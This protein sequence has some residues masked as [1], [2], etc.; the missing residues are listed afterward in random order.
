MPIDY[1]KFDAIDDSDEENQPASSSS[2]ADILRTLEGMQRSNPDAK[3]SGPLRSPRGF[4]DSWDDDLH[5]WDMGMRSPPSPEDDD[6]Y[7]LDFEA[8]NADALQ[9]LGAR[10]ASS[11]N[12]SGIGRSL[13][14]EAE[15]Q[16][17]ASRYREALI[18]SLAAQLVEDPS[19]LGGD[20]ADSVP[21][22]AIQMISAYQLGDRAEAT[23]LRDL[24][25][26]MP[27]HKLSEHLRKR[28][29]GTSE[30]LDLV[31]KF[32]DIMKNAEKEPD[33]GSF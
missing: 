13:L 31:P 6:S 25:K 8:L 24:L 30:V 3:Q 29:E 14:L 12:V 11:T 15:L 28:F 33:R 19:Q 10:L 22:L 5:D 32:L 26:E 18:A 9:L 16:L 4:G 7:S 2:V 21:A 17:V 23:Q 20:G 1:S 27:Q